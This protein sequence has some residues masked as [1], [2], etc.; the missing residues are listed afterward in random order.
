MPRLSTITRPSR[1]ARAQG[2]RRRQAQALNEISS[3]N[4]TLG[5]NQKALEY[6]KQALELNR[7]VEDRRGETIT[8]YNIARMER[9]L[10]NLVEARSQIEGR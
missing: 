3:V 8:L 6:S 10:G 4:D 1:S 9:D 5:E 2:D 7:A